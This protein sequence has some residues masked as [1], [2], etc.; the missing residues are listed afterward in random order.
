MEQK[1][2]QQDNLRELLGLDADAENDF[3]RLLKEKAESWKNPNP[4]D[5]PLIGVTADLNKN[6]EDAVEG[7]SKA[8]VSETG[9]DLNT[10]N[11]ESALVAGVRDEDVAGM[12]EIFDGKEHKLEVRGVPGYKYVTDVVDDTFTNDEDRKKA[13]I[14][15]FSTPITQ[16]SYEKALERIAREKR[17]VR[18]INDHI[19]GMH[20]GLEEVLK[21]MNEE[22]RAKVLEYDKKLEKE[23]AAKRK[24]KS[25][26]AKPK[27]ASTKAGPS[28]TEQELGLS[29]ADKKMIDGLKKNHF[30][31]EACTKMVQQL[32]KASDGVM[33]YIERVYSA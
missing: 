16:L 27:T 9:A 26:S 7:S 2:K 32:N 30:D 25:D 1:L 12:P 3:D 29:V 6:V 5:L 14:S 23:L 19:Q 22:Q 11:L 4:S 13:Y 28:K 10:S 18:L 15:G 20:R 17:L 21:N 31:K 8:I 24:A 33:R